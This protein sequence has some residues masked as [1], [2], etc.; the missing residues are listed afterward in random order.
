[1]LDSYIKFFA[2]HEKVILALVAAGAL[3][4]GV[5]KIDS[6][7]VNHDKANLAA[8]ALVVNADLAK[9]AAIAQQVLSDNATMKQMQAASD[10]KQAAL[11]AQVLSL[12]ATLASQQKKDATMT[13]TE[14]TA[15]WNTLVPNASAS[16]TPSGVTLPSAGAVATVQQLEIIPVQA[17]ELD[18]SNQRLVIEDGLLVQAQKTNG[19]LTTQVTGLK[20]LNV[21]A[22]KKCEDEKSVIKA[23]ARKSK[24]RYML[25]GV[26]ATVITLAKFG[27]L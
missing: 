16:V 8:Q 11:Q 12:I 22:A 17:K 1:M 10:A 9:N 7:I 23:E 5:S 2:A 6:L 26:I 13:P 20:V 19:D 24:L 27:A 21:D 3:L 4:G 18:A 25:G 14:L 15:R